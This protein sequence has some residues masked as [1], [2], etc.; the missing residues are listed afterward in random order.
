[1]TRFR[2]AAIV[3]LVIIPIIAGGFVMQERRA[4]SGS[5]LFDQVLAIISDRYVDSVE[6]GN[7]YEKAARGLVAELKDPYADLYTPK[8][9]EAFNTNTGGFYAGVGMQIEPQDGW[10]VIAKV[11]PNTPASEA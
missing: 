5:R 6:V 3:G 9:L 10:I 1:M 7:L 2:K 8:Q 11:F 4:V